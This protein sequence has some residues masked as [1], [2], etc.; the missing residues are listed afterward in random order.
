MIYGDTPW[1][2]LVKITVQVS[3]CHKILLKMKTIYAGI[4]IFAQW[5]DRL[6][7]FFEIML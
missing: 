3:S 5:Q 1:P 7:N 2:L 4:Y 6:N